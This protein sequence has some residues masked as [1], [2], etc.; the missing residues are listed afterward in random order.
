MKKILK[1]LSLAMC[2]ML[3]LS[4][5]SCGPFMSSASVNKVVKEFGTPQAEMT[6]KFTTSA[7][8]TYK[9]VFT[10]DLLLEKT[11]ITV[12]SFINLAQDG[13]YEDAIFDKYYPENN[14]FTAGKYTYRKNGDS[15]SL[16][17]YHNV[18]G[19]TIPGEFKTNYFK[20]PKGGY[21]QFSV[22]SLA[23]YHDNKAEYFDSANGTLIFSTAS[24]T[25]EQYKSLKYTNYAIFARMVE[26]KV[27][28]CKTED[29][30]ES[31]K[32]LG[33]YSAEMI[34]WY[35]DLLVDQTSNTTSCS[36]TNSS[37]DS[38]PE[39]VLGTGG[40]PRFIFSIKMLGDNDW[41]KLPKVN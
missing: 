1:I 2:V 29:G 4:L 9:Y 38:A 12:I 8:N 26:W 20:E 34:N 5:T 21:E 15:T 17:G 16:H 24:S 35:R 14:Y 19:I 23:M 27:Y 30:T 33:S 36:M 32:L 41:S 25:A 3:L 18:S 11:P 10:Y 22:F 28:L 7:N 13:F 31:E 37:G 6:L 40:I 39:T